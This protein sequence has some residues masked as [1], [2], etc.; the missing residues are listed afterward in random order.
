MNDKTYNGLTLGQIAD[1]ARASNPEL[2]AIGSS[3]VNYYTG[4]ANATFEDHEGEGAED[5]ALFLASA[6]EIVL[7]L[8]RRIVELEASQP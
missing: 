7:I 1:L 6:R 5:T 4:R 3:L 8:I 2:G